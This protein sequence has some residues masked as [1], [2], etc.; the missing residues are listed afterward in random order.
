ML[1]G[2]DIGTVICPDAEVKIFVTA[3]PEVRA[4][5]RVLEFQ[6]R[7]ERVNQADV[8]ADIRRRDERDSSR[9]IAP[10]RPASD[11][12]VLDTT[13]LDADACIC[14]GGRIDRA[15]CG[16]IQSFCRQPRRGSRFI[17]S[18][19]TIRIVTRSD[20]QIGKEMRA[21]RHPEH[22]DRPR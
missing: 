2:R 11:A 1:D 15:A 18:N 5:R 19:R 8:L 9:A 21:G 22:A 13:D 20:Q 12:H 10:L 6:A 17:A 3:E 16:V 7:G 14:G 4:S